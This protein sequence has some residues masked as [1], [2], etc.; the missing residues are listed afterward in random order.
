MAKKR[1]SDPFWEREKQKYDNPIP[2]R[3]SILNYLEDLGRP[4]GFKHLV[5]ATGIDSEEQQEALFF[6]L[7]AMLRDG[8]LMQ[9]RRNRYCI[10]KRLNLFR[11][12]IIGHVEG[13]GFL[14][15]DEGSDDLF[16]SAREMRSVMH[17]DVVLAFEV[18]RDKKGR[19]EGK[20]HEV[21]ERGH[22]NIVG[23]F[24]SENGVCF[25]EPDNKRLNQAIAVA[26]EET[27]GAQNGQMVLLEMLAYPAKRHPGLGRVVEILGDH[28]APG[29]EIDVALY[30]NDIPFEW[31]ETV[32]EEVAKFP[33]EVTE[34][35]LKGRQDLRALDFV[36]IDGEDARDFDDAV[37]CKAKSA[38]GWVLYVA[39]AD[40]SHYVSPDSSLDKEA[41]R[42]ATSVYF[43][44]RVI[45]MLPE[46]L[47]N[48]LCSLNPH[49]DRLCLVCELSISAQGRI[50]RSRF[51]RAVIHSK[52]RLTYTQVANVFA[53][54]PRSKE[55]PDLTDAYALYQ[56]LLKARVA[57]GAMSFESTES[58]IKFDSNKKIKK[59]VPI[60][61]N[62][63]HCLIEEFMLAANVA[64][65]R[66]VKRLKIPSLYRV[67]QSP[68]EEKVEKLREF[69]NGF[70]LSLGGG[71]KPTP[72][73]YCAVL[74]NIGKRPDKS[75][76]ETVML[77]SLSQ[78]N[79][80][81]KNDG[82]FG[83]AYA[84]YAHFTSPIRRYPD[85][86]THRAITFAL[87]HQG[88]EESFLYNLKEMAE[89]GRHC[90][91]CERRA[92]EATRDVVS[93][94]KCEFMQD[95]L[96][97]A[98][99]GTISGVTSFGVFVTLD[100]VFVDGLVHMSQLKGDYYKFDPVRHRLLGQ[101]T[102]I[103]YRLGDKLEVSV[104]SVNLEDRKIDFELVENDEE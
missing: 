84:E 51:Y 99:L 73:D 55:M 93:W 20:V 10:M 66:F 37:Y 89:F 59:I 23:R 25:V 104:A 30:A 83:L 11:G 98:Y 7:K 101:R 54:A 18:G 92:D 2:S 42:R 19:R 64:A 12:K 94:L 65:A 17:G 95:K 48:G 61:R 5:D 68:G 38:G 27:L 80:V 46:Q 4:A 100:D 15:P 71:K 52:A 3:E 29:M 41:L 76:I 50:A 57:R 6:R 9:D 69:L 81:E 90:S 24:F 62:E 28:L 31:P 43:P 26:D 34:E 67:H 63:A 39:I 1:F 21:V 96:G 44:G 87:N 85:L 77:R 74:A 91:Y 75:L 88:P 49:V 79:Y 14:V 102:N 78:A 103:E 60:H 47:S 22:K 16:L 33:L 56:V 40:V 82:H 45:P 8:Q 86:L 58:L 53:G 35:D 97:N 32:L 13:Y 36:T 70:G 72:K